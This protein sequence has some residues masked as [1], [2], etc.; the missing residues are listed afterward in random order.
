MSCGNFEVKPLRLKCVIPPELKQRHFFATCEPKVEHRAVRPVKLQDASHHEMKMPVSKKRPAKTT[1]LKVKNGSAVD[2]KS[3]LHNKSRVFVA[4]DGS[5]YS[6]VL[7]LTDIMKNKNSYYKLQV[8]ESEG[9]ATKK[10]WLFTSWGRIGTEIG[11][12]KVQAYDQQLACVE[13]ERLFK[14]QTGNDWSERANFKRWPGKFYPID[15]SYGEDIEANIAIASRLTPQVGELMKLLFNVQE[16]KTV[17]KEFKLDLQKLPLGKL[18]A[19]QLQSAV[20]ALTELENAVKADRSKNEL[21]GLSN[22]FFTL[23]PHNFGLEKVPILD[24]IDQINRKR[25]MVDSLIDIQNAYAMMLKGNAAQGVN[26]FDAY[27]KQ[28]NAKLVLLDPKSEEFNLIQTYTVNTQYHGYKI[29]VE[30]VFKVEREGEEA[31]YAPFKGLHNRQML[32]HGSRITNFASIISNGLKIA[33]V[34]HGSMFG[35]GIYFADMVSLKFDNALIIILTLLF[36]L[37]SAS[38][39]TTVVNS[40]RSQL[41]LAY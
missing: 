14:E 25:E 18:S 24:T 36:H 6:S 35:R 33:P 39:Q 38:Q 28:L 26:S 30:E 37:R 31:R 12:S 5:L 3:K 7:G 11:D 34:V 40:V 15:V 19:K 4:S 20:I 8:L 23:I 1:T 22:K 16:M 13:F 27:Y 21:I 17:M 29:T 32:W 41:A 10:F 9:L 2:P